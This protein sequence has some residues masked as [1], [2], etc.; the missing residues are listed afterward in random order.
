MMGCTK[1]L[2]GV[3]SRRYNFFLKQKEKQTRGEAYLSFQQ[4]DEV[5]TEN[6]CQYK[7]KKD[8]KV[9]DVYFGQTTGVAI[10]SKQLGEKIRDN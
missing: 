7:K 2:T 1:W 5:G 3:L 9:I 4:E 8:G 6:R 10:L